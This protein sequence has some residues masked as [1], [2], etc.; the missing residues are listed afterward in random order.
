MPDID[1]AQEFHMASGIGLIV[2]GWGKV[3]II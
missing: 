3:L 1:I 2:S